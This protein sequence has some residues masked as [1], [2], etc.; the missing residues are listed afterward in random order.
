MTFQTYLTECK[1]PNGAVGDAVRFLRKDL[2]VLEILNAPELEAYLRA[3]G[4]T[5]QV[6]SA[7]DE[8]WQLYR[9]QEVRA[10]RRLALDLDTVMR[11]RRSQRHL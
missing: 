11:V 2:G 9:K 5:S 3:S 7:A 6:S 4:A 8:V 1:A 10:P